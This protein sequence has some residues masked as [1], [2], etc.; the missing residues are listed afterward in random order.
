MAE[1]TGYPAVDLALAD[2][3]ARSPEAAEAALAGFEALTWG[4]G[5][6]AITGH[7]LADFLWYQL[8]LKWMC[9]LDDKQR[10]AAALG[11]LFARLG[12]PRYAA[13]CASV[14]TTDILAAYEQDGEAAGL[15][16][17]RAALI[18]TGYAPPDIPNLID[19]GSV[20][21]TEEASAYWSASVALEHAI[22]AGEFK[23]GKAGWRKTAQRITTEFLHSPRDEVTGA[24]WLQ[25]MNTERLQRWADSR[26]RT[27]RKLAGALADQLTNPALAPIDA[28]RHLAPVQWLLDHAAAGAPLTQT[29]NLARAIVAEGCRRFDWLTLTGNPRSESD[30]V[31]LWTL[32]DLAKQMSVIRRS[33]RTLL[34]STTGKAVHAGDTDTLWQATM[35]CLPGPADGEAAAAEI[36]LMLLLDRPLNYPDLNESVAQALA[37]EGWR[38]QHTDQPI[39]SDHTAS[40][41]GE[42]RRRLDLLNLTATKRLGEATK[43]TD[44]GRRAAHTALRARALRPRSHPYG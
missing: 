23:P 36:A 16:A 29:G 32:R 12:Q 44:A 35:S 19:W 2:I 34:L 31:E 24:T 39:T 41:L 30:I 38:S 8:P 25:W 3:T 22:N 21:G 1:S 42:L 4:E 27:R 40:L 15:K 43:L 9:D 20:M 26:G 37:E 17:Y 10:V 13:L 33:G 28:A 6:D 14:T 18:A 7:G 5:P 11:D